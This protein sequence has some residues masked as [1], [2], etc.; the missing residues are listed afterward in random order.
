MRIGR[1]LAA[2]LATMAVAGCHSSQ[3]ASASSERRGSGLSEAQIA[4]A[5]NSV[6]GRRTAETF[7]RSHLAT[8]TP[9]RAAVV[10]IS[11]SWKSLR[12]V[13]NGL[14]LQLDLSDNGLVMA[15]MVKR[16]YLAPT[17]VDYARGSFKLDPKGAVVGTLSKPPRSLVRFTP[18]SVVRGPNGEPVLKSP[19]GSFP[20]VRGSEM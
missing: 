11:G 5:Q 4:R 19:A 10:R 14:W 16:A 8:M 3:K 13:R 15:R 17:L 9:E 12:E 20:L 18:W 7:R 1:V 2:A 6:Q